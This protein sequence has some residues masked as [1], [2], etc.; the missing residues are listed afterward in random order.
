MWI[1]TEIEFRDDRGNI[2]FVTVGG[3]VHGGDVENM[4]FKLNGRDI[5]DALH[6]VEC[7]YMPLLV[8][9]AINQKADA[10]YERTT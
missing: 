10:L 3:E 2:L 5:S 4:T 9:E 8:Q 1:E 6:D 7:D